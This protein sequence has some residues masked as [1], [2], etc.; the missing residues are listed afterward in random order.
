MEWDEENKI[1]DKLSW[2]DDR[3][4]TRLFIKKD[5]LSYKISS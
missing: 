5:L 1:N 2:K 4:K 3:I